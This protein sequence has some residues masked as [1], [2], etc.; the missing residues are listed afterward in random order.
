[1]VSGAKFRG[2][3]Q[4]FKNAEGALLVRTSAYW[5]VG[6]KR[7]APSP[8]ALRSRRR[9]AAAAP[10]RSGLHPS[11]QQP[12]CSHGPPPC[13]PSVCSWLAPLFA[14]SPSQ[15]LVCPFS[16]AWLQHVDAA[17]ARGPG[18]CGTG[19]GGGASRCGLWRR[20]GG[21]CIAAGR[22]VMCD[23]HRCLLLPAGCRQNSD[24]RD[25]PAPQGPLPLPRWVR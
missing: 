1:M 18:R 2:V 25:R 17:A 24:S 4:F 11:C 23:I 6:R 13:P 12:G 16:R 22:H 5:I 7:G 15:R 19:R 21:A 20:R 3:A 9:R 14:S 8:R 10:Q